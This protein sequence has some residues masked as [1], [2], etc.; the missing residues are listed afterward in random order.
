MTFVD[1][2]RQ[3]FYFPKQ[4][5]I[6]SPKVSIN[7]LPNTHALPIAETIEK[8]LLAALEHV[9]PVEDWNLKRNNAQKGS[10]EINA[11]AEGISQYTFRYCRF[12][13]V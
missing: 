11:A 4:N 8:R 10:Q 3:Q 6:A 2:D 9:G 13:L 12:L 7:I 1:M 5:I